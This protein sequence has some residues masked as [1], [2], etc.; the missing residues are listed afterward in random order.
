MKHQHV[1]SA[2]ER[3]HR[4][5]DRPLQTWLSELCADAFTLL[6]ERAC[7]SSTMI[8]GTGVAFAD[9][10]GAPPA[11]AEEF[12]T[13][14]R[15]HMGAY[16]TPALF[17][18]TFRRPSLLW[19]WSE[20]DF[21]GK[22]ES[23]APYMQRMGAQDAFALTMEP[24][25]GTGFMMIVGQARSRRLG[26]AE[27]AELTRLAIHVDSAVRARLGAAKVIGTIDPRGRLELGERVPSRAIR[28]GLTGDVARIED[29]RT[30]AH[31]EDGERA[32]ALWRALSSGLL[33]L[34]ERTGSDGKRLYEIL[35][36]PPHHRAVRALGPLHAQVVEYASRGVAN[37]EIAYA[38][39]I[40]APYVSVLLRDA[41]LRVGL[42]NARSLVRATSAL[43]GR[44]PSAGVALTPAERGVV[45]LLSEGL[46]NREIAGRRGVAERTIANQVAS[47]LAKT[48]SGSRRALLGRS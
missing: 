29:V 32:L 1:V 4:A 17:D 7:L 10:H 12:R 38:L 2:L 15:E 18:F 8:D 41:A 31:R 5:D 13:F 23:S 11:T 22:A 34:R 44:S 42:T 21:A 19:Q 46:S 16:L 27:R 6:D 36:N 37:K 28:E 48:G 45:E 25:I 43:A 35:E 39:G 24:V 14:T 33:S 26:R 30:A 9:L 47:V 3:I 40:S 20:T